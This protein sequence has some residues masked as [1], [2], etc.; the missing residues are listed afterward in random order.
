VWARSRGGGGEAVGSEGFPLLSMPR[1]IRPDLGFL[2]FGSGHG[3]PHYPEDWDRP[4]SGRDR[5]GRP[6]LDLGPVRV[7]I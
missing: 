7:E 1:E 6:R 2:F 3:G 4:R 5:R